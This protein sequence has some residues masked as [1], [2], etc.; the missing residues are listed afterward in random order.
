MI[1]TFDLFPSALGRIMYDDAANIKETIIGMIDGSPM[2]PNA[3]EPALLHFENS[4]NQ[5]FLHKESLSGFRD[6]IEQ[7]CTEFVHKSLGYSADKMITTDSWL[8]LCNA[9][10]GQYPHFHGNAYISGTYYVHFREGHSPLTFRHP[11][12]STHSQFPSIS[13]QSDKENP[14]KYNSD[15]FIYPAEGE[16]LLWQS[17]LTHGYTDNAVGNRISISMNFMPEIVNNDRYAYKVV[18]LHK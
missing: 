8:N 2:E 15:V 4:A 6:W 12:N 18:P 5:S 1:E 17:H 13:L 11:E 16:L 7:Q 9:G 3:K 10:G 14:N